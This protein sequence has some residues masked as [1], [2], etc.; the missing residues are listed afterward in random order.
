MDDVLFEDVQQVF[1]ELL[2]Q[3]GCLIA[4]VR[5]VYGGAFHHYIITLPSPHCLLCFL[6]FPC[7]HYIYIDRHTQTVRSPSGKQLVI[8]GSDATTAIWEQNGTDFQRVFTL[9]VS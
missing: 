4:K 3:R 7:S 2:Q 8:A 1:E 9:E 5:E 6:S